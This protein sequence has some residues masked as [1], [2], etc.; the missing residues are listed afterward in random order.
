MWSVY[1]VG[2]QCEDLSFFQ[3]QGWYLIYKE[4]AFA[5]S[6]QGSNL[7]D[8]HRPCSGVWNLSQVQ[9]EVIE[10]FEGRE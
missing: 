1:T 8:P 5:R 2:A 7:V 9:G 3:M 10:R 6:R 4:A